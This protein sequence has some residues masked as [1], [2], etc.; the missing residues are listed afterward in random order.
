MPD[1]LIIC[2][3]WAL[4]DAH[5]DSKKWQIV[6]PICILMKFDHSDIAKLHQYWY[7]Y[8]SLSISIRIFWHLWVF[9]SVRFKLSSMDKTILYTDTL[10]VLGIGIGII[11]KNWSYRYQ[12]IGQ[13]LQKSIG[14]GMYLQTCI[15]ISVFSHVWVL[16]WIFSVLSIGIL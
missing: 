4:S 1:T 11:D 10:P 16:I 13:N 7:Q 8:K 9:A 6:R 15:G 3:F 14:I 12:Y 5:N 2:F